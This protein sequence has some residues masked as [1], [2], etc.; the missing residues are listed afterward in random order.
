LYGLTSGVS[1]LIDP[2]IVC[3]TE[4]LVKVIL[5]PAA[6]LFAL[7]LLLAPVLKAILPPTPVL[8]IPTDNVIASPVEALLVTLK[9]I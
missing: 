5:P 9:E 8:S 6:L 3:K 2:L 1:N 7:E 4:P